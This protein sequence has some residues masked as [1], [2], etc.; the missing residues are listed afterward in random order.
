MATLFDDT[1][2]GPRWRYGLT[3]RPLGA[4]VPSG[5]IVFSD[6]PSEDPRCRAFGTVEYPLPLAPDQVKQLSLI[7]F[8]MVDDGSS[9]QH[10]NLTA[11]LLR[12]LN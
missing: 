1:Y 5:W 8:G 3:L 9:D 4:G 7:D 10:P 11:Q 6:R 2:L 12:A